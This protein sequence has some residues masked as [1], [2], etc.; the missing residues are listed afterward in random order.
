MNKAL[1]KGAM[2][3]YGDTQL[4]LS[5]ALGISQSRL[6][7]KINGRHNAVFTQDEMA[8]IISRYQLSKDRVMSIFF[9]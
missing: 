7:A 4:T 8:F 5:L 9:T 3:E 2:A 6:N 1:L